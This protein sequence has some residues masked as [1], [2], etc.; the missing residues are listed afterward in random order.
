M[1]SECLVFC[2]KNT[3]SAF[4][5]ACYKFVFAF[6]YSSYGKSLFWGDLYLGFTTVNY[7]S[8]QRSCFPKWTSKPIKIVCQ[9]TVKIL[10]NGTPSEMPDVI[11]PTRKVRWIPPM[12]SYFFC[13]PLGWYMIPLQ[14]YSIL[15]K[16]VPSAPFWKNNFQIYPNFVHVLWWVVP[17]LKPKH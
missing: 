16:F 10:G 3:W 8:I 17:K 14:M 15:L 7:V 2:E 12:N 5:T 9:H 1:S 4:L 6:G 13:L 11:L